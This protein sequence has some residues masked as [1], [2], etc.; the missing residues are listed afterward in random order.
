EPERGAALEQAGAAAHADRGRCRRKRGDR[1][2]R[3]GIG[4]NRIAETGRVPE[5]DTRLVLD[6]E[7]DREVP[8]QLAEAVLMPDLGFGGQI[9][10]IKIDQIDVLD[11]ELSWFPKR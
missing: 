4:R 11:A 5:M 7:L 6:V 10:R 1:V 2:L 3:R 9:L 8:E